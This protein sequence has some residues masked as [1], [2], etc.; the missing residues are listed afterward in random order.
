MHAKPFVGGG[1]LVVLGGL[2]GV[3]GPRV[4][5][6]RYTSWVCTAF[7]ARC[8]CR[9]DTP[10]CIHGRRCVLMLHRGEYAA[11]AGMAVARRW[12]RLTR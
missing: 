3:N 8:E 11:V 5:M 12:P 2:R 7:R 1:Q 10:L 4:T 6:V 9:R